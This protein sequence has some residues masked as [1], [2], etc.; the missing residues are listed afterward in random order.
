MPPWIE[1]QWIEMQMQLQYLYGG[2]GRSGSG[3]TSKTSGGGGLPIQNALA[4][5]MLAGTDVE[6]TEGTSSLTIGDRNTYSSLYKWV[7]G[8]QISPS[9]WNI[10]AANALANN[11]QRI[12]RCSEALDLIP[13]YGSVPN[14]YWLAR[15]AGGILLRQMKQEPDIYI[16]CM[17]AGKGRM[18]NEVTMALLFDE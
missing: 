15:Q 2:G 10:Q 13:R 6:D 3:G 1:A 4:T 12:L 5:L 8:E 11:Y 17:N 9:E 16:G 18:R 14:Y 7:T